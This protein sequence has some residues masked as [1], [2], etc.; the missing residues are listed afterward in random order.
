MFVASYPARSGQM[1]Q[2]L[3]ARDR[4]ENPIAFCGQSSNDDEGKLEMARLMY[5]CEVLKIT[6]VNIKNFH[7]CINFN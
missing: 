7:L 2:Y 1:L 4:C 6:L 5:S 3:E